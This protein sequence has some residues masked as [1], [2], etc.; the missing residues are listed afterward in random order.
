M[1]PPS[2]PLRG[3]FAASASRQLAWGA[4]SYPGIPRCQHSRSPTRNYLLVWTPAGAGRWRRKA[5]HHSN[6]PEHPSRRGQSAGR[7]R[8]TTTCAS[9]RPWVGADVVHRGDRP[10]DTASLS[11]RGGLDDIVRRLRRLACPAIQL[12]GEQSGHW[13]GGRGHAHLAEQRK[14]RPV[15]HICK[16][17][18]FVPT[19]RYRAARWTTQRLRPGRVFCAPADG[20][21]YT[22][23]G[24]ENRAACRPVWW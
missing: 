22:W 5:H 2:L 10:Q 7:H 23:P 13:L 17:R 18:P 12:R 3:T 11:R 6:A 21:S 9:G 20:L 4:E 1:K 16:E 8:P 14:G 19:D 24:A 15:R